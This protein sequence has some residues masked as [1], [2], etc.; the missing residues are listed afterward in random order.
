MQLTSLLLAILNSLP[1]S[2]AGMQGDF[3]EVLQAILQ[4]HARKVERIKEVVVAIYTCLQVHPNTHWVRKLALKALGYLLP[5]HLEKIVHSCLSFSLPVN[6]QAMELWTVMASG[7]QV[8]KQVLQILLKSLQVKDPCKSNKDVITTSLAAM[9]VIYESF[10]I[11]TYNTAMMEMQH[12]FFIP[13]LRQVEYVQQ[14]ALPK[15]LRARKK[16]FMSKSVEIVKGL[17]LVAKDWTV[18]ACVQAQE[19]WMMLG[20]PGKFFQSTHLLARAMKECDSPQIPGVRSQAILIL[21]CDKDEKKERMAMALMA[22]FLKS[23]PALQPIDRS[24]IRHQLKEAAASSSLVLKDLFLEALKSLS[25]PR[26][27]ECLRDQL[28]KIMESAFS[29]HERDIIE[30]LKEMIATLHDLDDQGIGAL[31]LEVAM[32][33]RSFFDDVSTKHG[34]TYDCPS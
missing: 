18:F 21:N 34:Q 32:N 4:N 22:E 15:A 6:R 2:N 10:A 9:N 12:Q 23:P 13:V 24:T 1:G 25:E 31:I 28:P 7:P 29:G 19:G 30:G 20:T 17:F 11:A 5:H 8:A 16:E 3:E 27:V 26:E 33:I 14:L